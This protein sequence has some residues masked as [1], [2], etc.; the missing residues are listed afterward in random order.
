MANYY[1]SARSNYFRV[2]DIE[3]FKAA[4]HPDIEVSYE[5]HVP[6]GHTPE[7]GTRVCLLC[8]ADGG[9]PCMIDPDPFNSDSEYVDWDVLD[10]VAPHLAVGEW[11]VIQE[12]GSEKLRYLTGYSRAI[13]NK[14]QL[15]SVDI[16]DIF[17]QL[18]DYVSQC[19][20]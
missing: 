9:W 1:A 2:K 13:N 20:Y 14:G 8:E 17:K 6:D 19:E 12:V 16:N 11:C 3:A 4:M 7:P 5:G 15:I 18:P 10:A